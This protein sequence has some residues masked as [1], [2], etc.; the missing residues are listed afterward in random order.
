MNAIHDYNYQTI[1]YRP[2]WLTMCAC[3]RFKTVQQNNIML[4]V[5]YCGDGSSRGLLSSIENVDPSHLRGRRRKGDRSCVSKLHK[6][7]ELVDSWG[8]RG[9]TSCNSLIMSQHN[10]V[11]D[12]IPLPVFAFSTHDDACYPY[13]YLL[14][15]LM[16]TH[17]IL[18]S[19][20]AT[21]CR[22]PCKVCIY[23]TCQVVKC[24]AIHG[25]SLMAVCQSAR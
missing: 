6:S 17:A 25:M 8:L 15:A 11:D 10:I 24:N 21:I 9:V 14:L 19:M 16:M 7:I 12:A 4:R 13:Q 1:Q 2:V 18:L 5:S 23:T 20:Y 3:A 22:H